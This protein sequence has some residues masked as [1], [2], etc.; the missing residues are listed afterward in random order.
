MG[1]GYLR[2]VTTAE[3]ATV[4]PT[5]RSLKLLREMG[6]VAQTVEY[7]HAP[8]RRRRDLFGCIDIIACHREHGIL[9]V[10]A[11]SRVN[12]STRVKKCQQSPQILE[13]LLAGGALQVWSWAKVKGRWQVKSESILP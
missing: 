5:A 3:A 8:S 2:T 10:Q 11:T 9:G 4:S 6:Y 13:W 7:W 12:H 1:R